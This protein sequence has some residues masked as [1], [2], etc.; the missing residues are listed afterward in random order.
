MSYS[1]YLLAYHCGLGYIVA[2][3]HPLDDTDHLPNDTANC[4]PQSGLNSKKNQNQSSLCAPKGKGDFEPLAGRWFACSCF[5]QIVIL[6]APPTFC[7]AK[8]ALVECER[9]GNGVRKS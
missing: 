1:T 8:R 3:I 2:Q 6:Q 9:M 7:V 4:L 5:S